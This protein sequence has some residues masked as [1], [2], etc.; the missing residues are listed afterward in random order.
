MQKSKWNDYSYTILLCV[1]ILFAVL[2][3][4]AN[5]FFIEKAE[6]A[7]Q[8][9]SAELENIV[10]S[11]KDEVLEFVD[12]FTP[13]Q[14]L[15]SGAENEASAN[16][17]MESSEM[18]ASMDGVQ[19][20]ELP[21]NLAIGSASEADV[22]DVS[23]EYGTEIET[24][25]EGTQAAVMEETQIEEQPVIFHADISYFD[26]ALFIGD[27]RTVGLYEYGGLGKAEVFADTGMNIY[28][29]FTEKFKLQNGEEITLE[30]ALQTMDFGKVY[31]MLGINELGYDFEQTVARFS[32]TIDTIIK[33]Q[34]D[35]VVFIQANL[36]ITKEK[37]EE[38]EYFTNS[39]IDK[40]NSAISE[41]ANDSQIFYLDANP[42]YDDEEGYLSTEF[43]TDHA[44]ILGKYYVD[45]VDFIL[46]NAVKG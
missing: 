5:T 20:V 8:F 6:N 27:S 12:L 37:S 23:Q 26:D 34:P 44:H 24:A 31:I 33:Y 30:T 15:A 19:E 39:N 11:M 36:H 25:I 21:D 42:L 16:V 41:L 46:Q 7:G 45:W 1:S 17:N 28:K 22:A 38:S 2:L 14:I 9:F 4:I 35:A 43:T 40:Y 13:G 32:E 29:V 18:A 10:G 3:W